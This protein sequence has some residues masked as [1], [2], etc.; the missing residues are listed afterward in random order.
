[1]LMKMIADLLCSLCV[2]INCVTIANAR[3]HY[4]ARIGDRPGERRVQ[5]LHFQ[6]EQSSVHNQPISQDQLLF[7]PHFASSDPQVRLLG[8]NANQR[9]IPPTPAPLPIADIQTRLHSNFANDFATRVAT[10]PKADFIAL[11][12]PMGHAQGGNPCAASGHK[13]AKF[14]SSQAQKRRRILYPLVQQAACRHRIPVDLFDAMI[15]Q[16]SEYDVLA[17]SNVGAFGL[18]QLMPGTARDLGADRYSIRSNLDGGARYLKAQLNR[19]AS[20]P[21]ALAAYNAGPA[22]VAV[23]LAIPNI[24]ET[25]NY[26]ASIIAKWRRLSREQPLQSVSATLPERPNNPPMIDDLNRA[27]LKIE[28]RASRS[29]SVFQF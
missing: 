15:M 16:E 5:I 18:A 14:L 26:V 21:L 2:L 17:R 25:K 29:A 28:S 20:A 9:L 3:T 24:S 13:P 4:P 22:R 12:T 1:M 8:V 27:V 23:R 7:V 10:R 11:L 19:F 6:A